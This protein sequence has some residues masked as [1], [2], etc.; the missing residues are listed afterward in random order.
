MSDFGDDPP[1]M[2][3]Q[4]RWLILENRRLQRELDKAENQ[5][6]HWKEQEAKQRRL[7]HEQGDWKHRALAAELNA[8]KARVKNRMCRC[9]A[10]DPAGHVHLPPLVLDQMYEHPEQFTH[11]SKDEYIRMLIEDIRYY[12][13]KLGDS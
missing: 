11:L 5:V 9:E 2:A 13:A 10:G 3:E 7:H 6:R 8:A 1:P 4:L 12:L